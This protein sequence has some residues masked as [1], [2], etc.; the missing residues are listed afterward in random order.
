MIRHTAVH[1]FV[2]APTFFQLDICM[3]LR[4]DV[5]KLQ[6]RTRMY[7]TVT[8]GF[9]RILQLIKVENKEGY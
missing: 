9:D 8:M 3:S 6:I 4:L 5:Y 7:S 2:M 1:Y